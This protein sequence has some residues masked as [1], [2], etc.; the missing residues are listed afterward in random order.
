MQLQQQETEA[1]A[2]YKK[3]TAESTVS[4]ASKLAE[5]KGASSE[6][7]SLDI[8]LNTHKEDYDITSQELQ[9]VMDYLEKLKPQCESS[10][11]SY[12]DKKARR[13]A[14]MGGLKEALGIL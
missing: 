4:K 2:E 12:A 9:T 10:V 13:E 6:I 11:M 14:E 7:K 1:E 8:A 3:L 5:V